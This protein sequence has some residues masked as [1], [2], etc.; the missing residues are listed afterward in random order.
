MVYTSYTLS[1]GTYWV[2]NP[3]HLRSTGKLRMA[4]KH[5]EY[6]V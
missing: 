5:E 3:K 2:Q 1:M 4:R 6:L